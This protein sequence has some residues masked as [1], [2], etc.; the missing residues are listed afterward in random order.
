MK[1]NG[2]IP[3]PPI[4]SFKADLL[5]VHVYNSH[6]DLARDAAEQAHA[7]LRDVL[8]TQ[9]QAR[10]ILA[11]AASQ[12]R[13]LDVL[14]ALPGLKWAAVTLFHMDEYLGVDDQHP[15]SFRRFMRERVEQRVK[16]KAFHYLAGECLE[17][18]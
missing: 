8:K 3:C 17:P 11:S 10:A 7:Y 4:R 2:S 14:T 16:P 18:I 15:A 12:T 13:F 9:G 1:S 6:D 5:N